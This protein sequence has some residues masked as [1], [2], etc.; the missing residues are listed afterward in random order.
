[1][2]NDFVKI[3]SRADAQ[4]FKDS[5]GVGAIFAMFLGMLYLPF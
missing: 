5:L 2:F 1:M 3:V 4:L